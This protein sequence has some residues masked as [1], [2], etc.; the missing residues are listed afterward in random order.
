MAS[1]GQR[2]IEDANYPAKDVEY[3][4][5]NLNATG[6]TALYNP[7][8]DAVAHG[9]HLQNGGST[10]VVQLEVTDGTDTAVLTPGQAAGDGIAWEPGEYGLDAGD[11]LQVNVTTAEGA[12][13]TN[14]AAVSHG[15]K[16]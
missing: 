1:G 9:V 4:S 5:V 16:T 3:A 12:A 14:T 13:Q 7:T 10:A 6:T 15:E 11:T 2:D 8:E